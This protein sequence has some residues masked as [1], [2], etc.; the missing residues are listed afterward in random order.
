MEKHILTYTSDGTDKT[1]VAITKIRNSGTDIIGEIVYM[2]TDEGAVILEDLI[3]H[4][5]YNALAKEVK[6]LR[7]AAERRRERTIRKVE[8]ALGL[9]LY[10]WQKAFIF[11]NKPYNYYVRGYRKTGKT[12][13]HC[14]RLCLSE[15][16]PIIAALTPSTR[17]KNEFLCYLGEDGCSIHRSQFFINELRQVYNKLL[18]AGNIDL[19]EI[20][21]KR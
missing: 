4:P 7:D 12:L 15:G 1:A 11:Y 16:E 10:D 20:T 21:F 13:A 18:A 17:A 6:E 19:R 3:E 14:L 2:G 5:G 9:K 8:Q